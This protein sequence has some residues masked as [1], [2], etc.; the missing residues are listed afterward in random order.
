[1]SNNRKEE[2]I[3]ATLEL[4]AR[5]G[6]G[7]VTTAMIADK[8]GIKKPSLYNHFTSKDEI[9]EEMY[10]YLREKAK[11]SLNIESVDYTVLFADKTAYEVLMHMVGDYKRMN[12]DNHM[13]M[14]YQ[15]IYSERSREP[16]AAKIMTEETNRMILATKQL[17]YALQVHNMLYFSNPDMS[18]VTFA[19]TVHG[20]IEY[21]FD[22]ETRNKEKTGGKVCEDPADDSLIKKYIQWFCEENAVEPK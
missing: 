9:V 5:N 14:F 18:A 22:L 15:V 10:K 13:W 16:M 3:L 11:V 7:S 6:L 2:I 4:A 12:Q 19:M 17:F 21:E 8:V 1:M 20:L